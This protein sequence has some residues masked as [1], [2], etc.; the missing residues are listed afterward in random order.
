M[1]EEVDVAFSDESLVDEREVDGSLL[2]ASSGRAE[3]E[4][5]A[6]RLLAEPLTKIR[7][8]IS[9]KRKNSYEQAMLYIPRNNLQH[10]GHHW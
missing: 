3:R 8:H 6:Q 10:R 9:Y 7:P 4:L 1:I 5:V 2:A